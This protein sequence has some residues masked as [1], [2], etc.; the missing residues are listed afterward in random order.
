MKCYYGS[1]V[2]RRIRHDNRPLRRT[3]TWPGCS[4]RRSDHSGT[5]TSASSWPRTSC[6]PPTG[7]RSPD[8][9]TSTCRVQ[10]RADT[11]ESSRRCLLHTGL[12]L[13]HRHRHTLDNWQ[14][15]V[16]TWPMTFVPCL[17]KDAPTLAS[18]D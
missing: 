5:V 6:R 10:V 3:S 4:G 1:S 13:R 18:A 15:H 16:S 7:R 17:S 12:Q 11:G 8:R 2:V 14:G 9:H